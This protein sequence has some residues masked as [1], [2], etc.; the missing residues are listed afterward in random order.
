MKPAGLTNKAHAAE[1]FFREADSSSA[2]QEILVILCI[3]KIHDRV[4]NCRQ[5]FPFLL[6]NNPV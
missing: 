1:F 6:Q 5:I 2:S 3:P 4:Q